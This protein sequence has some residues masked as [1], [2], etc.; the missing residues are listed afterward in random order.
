MAARARPVTAKASQANGRTC[1]FEVS[2]TTS[3]P[4]LKRVSM[5]TWRPLMKAATASLPISVWTA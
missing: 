1:D 4:F 2:I 3:S 5:G